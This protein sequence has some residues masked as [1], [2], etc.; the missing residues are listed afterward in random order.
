LKRS[1]ADIDRGSIVFYPRSKKQKNGFNMPV[2]RPV[3]PVATTDQTPSCLESRSVTPEDDVS[4]GLVSRLN[5]ALRCV[6]AQ[7]ALKHIEQFQQDEDSTSRLMK[8]GRFAALKANERD[9]SGSPPDVSASAISPDPLQNSNTPTGIDEEAEVLTRTTHR[10]TMAAKD[11]TRADTAPSPRTQV[12]DAWDRDNQVEAEEDGKEDDKEDEEQAPVDTAPQQERD[13][14]EVT[15]S[16][17]PPSE[18][19]Q[20]HDVE[21][22]LNQGPQI[23]KKPG[24]PPKPSRLSNVQESLPNGALS[25]KKRKPGGQKKNYPRLRGE[26]NKGYLIRIARLQKKA[27]PRLEDQDAHSFSRSPTVPNEPGSIQLAAKPDAPLKADPDEVAVTT[28][29]HAELGYRDGNIDD[30]SEDFRDGEQLVQCELLDAQ[31]KHD[32]DE[33][34][35]P[36]VS[37]D[38]GTH[39]EFVPESETDHGDDDDIELQSDFIDAFDT[40]LED[41]K[42]VDLSAEDS[43][44]RDVKDFISREPL[45]AHDDDVFESPYV[46]DVITIHLD[47]EPLRRVCKLLGDLSWAGVKGDWQW[48]HFAYHDA[49]T[50]PA[51]ALLPLLAK[52]ERLYEAT[53]RAPNLEEQNRFLSKHANMLRYYF[54]KINLAVEHIRAERLEIPERNTAAQNTNPRK[55]KRMTRDLVLY[56][57]PMMV[58]V[59]ACAWG[60]GGETWFQT[61]FTSVAVEL[62]ERML[63]WIMALHRRLLGELERCPLEEKPKTQYQQQTWQKRNAKRKEIGPLLDDLHRVIAAAPDR[64]ADTEARVKKESERR[65]E[66]LKREEKLKA[67]QKLAE[68]AR[69]VSI[70][71]RKK[72]SLLSI[73][74]IHYP[75]ESS[76]ASSRP[77]PSPIPRLTEWS[78]EEQTFLFKKIQESFPE[79]PDLNYLRWELNKTVMETAEM[80]K[81]LL[82][83]MLAAVKPD[84][85]PDER[86]A[87]V[88]RIMQRSKAV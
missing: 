8:E 49:E 85:S 78:L 21:L 4:E 72:R 73:R 33:H 54:H 68:E 57:I 66:Q 75:L 7:Q 81:Q 18:R 71:E 43:F 87:E 29:N 5:D 79:P 40:D 15:S 52:L 34:D 22:C 86:A 14:W 11:G 77:S 65:Q 88:R 82:E 19:R 61:S 41:D 58:H 46:D 83:K 39:S 51:R 31:D 55:R 16:R 32:E 48:R 12:N 9:L 17:R 63:G 35:G 24:R 26:T 2:P 30:P 37:G 59:L 84:K 1:L 27:I 76:T 50:V 3:P 10:E 38:D 47:Y 70:A 42:S 36:H 25:A 45:H 20:H 69:L 67:Q 74:G 64:L 53:P 80:T 13:V 23:M 60:L 62:V 56:V 28:A 6:Q 44:M